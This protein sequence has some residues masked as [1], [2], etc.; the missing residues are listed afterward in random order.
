MASVEETE[1]VV[2]VTEISTFSLFHPDS[3]MTV[4]FTER[5][6][7]DQ[8]LTRNN[9]TYTRNKALRDTQEYSTR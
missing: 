2:P 7:F 9:P 4:V 6:P 5:E 3:E 8:K 1:K